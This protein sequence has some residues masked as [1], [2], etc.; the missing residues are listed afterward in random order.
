MVEAGFPDFE[1]VAWWG[2]LAP[3]K[4]PSEIVGKLNHAIKEA[5][6]SKEVETQFAKNG[7]YANPGTPTEFTAFLNDD[8]ALWAKISKEGGVRLE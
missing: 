2:I 8:M 3:A 6:L 5:L 4:T 7:V 1:V